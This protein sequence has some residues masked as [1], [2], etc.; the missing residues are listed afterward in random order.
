MLRR[1]ASQYDQERTLG[2][3]GYS[4]LV[5]LRSSSRPIIHADDEDTNTKGRVDSIDAASFFYSSKNLA[6][7]LNYAGSR[8]TEILISPGYPVKLFEPRGEMCLT[9]RIR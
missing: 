4:S 5:R 3:A 9:L 6:S 1:C 7:V 8:K 2:R